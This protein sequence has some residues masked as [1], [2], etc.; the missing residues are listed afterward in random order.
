MPAPVEFLTSAEQAATANIEV[1][2]NGGGWTSEAIDAFEFAVG[3]WESLVTSPVI[4]EVDADFS[5]LGT[6]ILG[7][8]GPVTFRR[9]F[10]NAPQPG[11]WYPVATAN[12]LAGFDLEPGVADIEATLSNTFTDW[13]F[14]TDSITDPTNISFASVVL[15]EL[16]HGLGFLGSMRVDDGT[17]IDECRG[18]AGEGCYGYFGSPM[19]YDLFTEN[20][21]GNSLTS[22]SNNSS[23]LEGQLTS[24][25]VFFNSPMGNSSNS[26]LRVPIYAP[27]E[28]ERGSSYSHLDE[29]FNSS[30]HALMTYS[31]SRGETIH[32][33]GAITLCMFAEMGWTVSETCILNPEIPISGLEAFNDGPT[34]LGSATHFS[35]NL[36]D[37]S[38]VDYIWDF[39]DSTIGSG[40]FPEHTYTSPGIYTAEVTASNPVSDETATTL[41]FITEQFELIYMPLQAKQ[42]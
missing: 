42:P 18:T 35:S 21:E 37:G 27:D 5:P 24:N 12:K 36:T 31:I 4:I 8:A 2:Y 40:A 33:P 38:N 19:I 9:N 32:H 25:S 39:G 6:N 10:P 29:D 41:V 14:G 7:G 34:I 17:G 3:I 22:F 30:N 20:S 11:T 15:H 26:G 23:E 28:W 13:D 1:N 16:G